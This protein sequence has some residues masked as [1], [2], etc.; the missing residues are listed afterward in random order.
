MAS[1]LNNCEEVCK[2]YA[3]NNQVDKCYKD[4]ENFNKWRVKSVLVT[5]SRESDVVESNYRN[6]KERGE[7]KSRCACPGWLIAVL[8]LIILVIVFLA[9]F[10]PILLIIINNGKHK[11]L[12]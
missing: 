1:Q 4:S 11:S 12:L 6:L 2:Y 5:T 3:D 7:K 10:L 8:V 9:I